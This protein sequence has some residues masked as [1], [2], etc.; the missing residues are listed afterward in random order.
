MLIEIKITHQELAWLG[1]R[2]FLFLAFHFDVFDWHSPLNQELNNGLGL[3]ALYNHLLA[4][5]VTRYRV[6]YEE[7]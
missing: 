4:G 2:D 5:P 6:N 1:R 7:A 3:F